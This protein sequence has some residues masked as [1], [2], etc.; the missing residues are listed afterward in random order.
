MFS[1]AL[2]ACAGPVLAGAEIETL[3]QLAPLAGARDERRV[4]ADGVVERWV[5]LPDG[6]SISGPAFDALRKEQHQAALAARG[7]LD[8]VL[9]EY[10]PQ[11]GATEIT[12]VAFWLVD[13]WSGSSPVRQIRS[14]IQGVDVDVLP[15]TVRA[16]RV[17]L[18]SQAAAAHRGNRQAFADAVRELGG[19]VVD[20]PDEVPV[21]IARVTASQA[22]ELA[23]HELVDEAYRSMPYWETEGDNAQG[24]LRTTTV[25]DTGLTGA[26]SP[27]RVLVNDTSD[28]YHPHPFLPNVIQLGTPGS[29]A[30]HATGV[31]GNIANTHP[32]YFAAAFGIP[33][34]Y[35]DGGSGDSTAPGIW[36]NAV[37]EGIDWGNCSWWNFQKGSIQFLDRF[38]DYT[39]RNFGVLMFKS[40]GNQGNTSTP[41]ATT[42]GNGFNVLCTGNYS[43]D[44]NWDWSDDEMASS[45][46]Y[47]NP[48]EGHDKPEVASPGSGVATT[49]T[50]GGIQSSFGGTSSASPLTC[51]VATLIASGDPTLLSQ[52]TT[53]KAVLMASAWHNVEGDP[54]LSEKD[55]AGGVHSA[56]AWATVRDG[57]WF[58]ADVTEDDFTADVL[59]VTADLLA[60]DETRVV[61][62]WFSNAD[63]SYSTDVLDMDLDM[64]VV[65]PSGS[66]VTS[67]TSPVNPFEIA[68]FI[69]SESGTYEFRLTK[70][71]FDG[72]SEPLT[73]A[74]ST[75][76]D[77]ATATVQLAGGAT[78]VPVGG[79]ATIEVEE[80][81][82]GAFRGYGILFSGSAGTGVPIPGGWTMPV[83]FDATAQNFLNT[84]PGASGVLDANGQATAVLSAPTDP[85]LAGL[86]GYLSGAVFTGASINVNQILS[87]APVTEI[88]LVP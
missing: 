42:P 85:G 64:T 17:E 84:V 32:E 30:S 48:V 53:V 76:A 14:A 1:T 75:R 65:D 49:T 38:F 31:A 51:G 21:V 34:I 67:S 27:V 41:Y 2:L 11:L 88:T 45:S 68:S 13:D 69:P 40:N 19:S 20:G 70:Q 4:S 80:P 9:H 23:L 61:A 58:H 28:V 36:M 7:K 54:L 26:G 25:H 5:V 12:E 86:T 73:V 57:Q 46:S 8:P 37:G 81:Y 35:T 52:M 63:S 50:G 6:Q 82:S 77:T 24:T 71:R 44:N 15:D 66:V 72:A 3:T 78:E 83:T 59:T 62:L 74:W 18:Q 29:Q 55:G 22:R 56:A 47:W 10:L 79:S 87:L 43:D 33:Q 60:G 39:I 16:V